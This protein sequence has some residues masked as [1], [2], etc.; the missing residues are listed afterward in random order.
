VRGTSNPNSPDHGTAPLPISDAQINEWETIAATGGTAVCSSGSY[1]ISSGSVT[2]GPIKIPCDFIVS[3]TSQ[4]TIA[5]HIWV[6][7]N[8]TIQNSAAIKMAPALGAANVAIIADKPSNQL[9]SSKIAVKNTA[10]FQ[11]SGTAGSFIFLI[12]QNNSAE[13]GGSETAIDLGNSTA[14]MVAYAAHGLIPLENTVSLKEVTAYKITMRN[15]ANIIYD[16]GLPSAVFKSGPGGS[17]TFVPKS[18]VISQ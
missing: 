14:T 13:S 18:Y 9:T 6:T 2:I 5:G 3:G 7:G 15:S 10:T 12:S 4:V 16:T 1:Q 11:N 8:I 17:W